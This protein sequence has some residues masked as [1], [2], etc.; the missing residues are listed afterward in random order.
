MPVVEV[1]CL[2]F[3]VES[4]EAIW[5]DWN[6]GSLLHDRSTSFRVVEQMISGVFKRLPFVCCCV[7]MSW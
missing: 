5:W 7:R 6:G 4:Q 1:I 3:A 2:L